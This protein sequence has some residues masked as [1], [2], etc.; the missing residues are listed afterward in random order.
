MNKHNKTSQAPCSSWLLT[1]NPLPTQASIL[2]LLPLLFRGGHAITL[3]EVVDRSTYAAAS[4]GGA[5][6]GHMLWSMHLNTGMWQ[7]CRPLGAPQF[8]A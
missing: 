2:L 1:F 8:A 7:D 4:A 3:P 5:P 6:Y